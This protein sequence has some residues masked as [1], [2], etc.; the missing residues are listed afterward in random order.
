LKR[1]PLL[2]PAPKGASDFNDALGEGG[3][4][5]GYGRPKDGPRAS[6]T[7]P[8]WLRPPSHCSQNY[9]AETSGAPDCVRAPVRLRD[10]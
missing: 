2:W 7:P 10:R 4:A 3:D 8:G 1:T 6:F 9:R 5:I